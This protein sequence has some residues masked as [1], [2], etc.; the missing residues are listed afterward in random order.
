[1]R[2]LIAKY[3]KLIAAGHS[4]EQIKEDLDKQPLTEYE[5]EFIIKSL[6]RDSLIKKERI[7]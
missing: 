4:M 1:M 3:K 2:H 7:K 5:K 6:Q